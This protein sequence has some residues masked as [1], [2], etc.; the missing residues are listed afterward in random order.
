MLCA[1]SL[2]CFSLLGN[3][4]VQHAKERKKLIPVQIVSF[5]F[6]VFADTNKL[7]DLRMFMKQYQ[8][9]LEVKVSQRC[10]LYLCLHKGKIV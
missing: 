10:T 1:P 2:N 6:F 7:L 9:C 4:A 3:M 5:C 8:A